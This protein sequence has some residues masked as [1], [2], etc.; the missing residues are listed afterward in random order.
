M[1]DDASCPP[2]TTRTDST[3][4]GS[5]SPD[6][7][8]R[9]LCP[10]GRVDL[11]NLSFPELERFVTVDLGQP[12]FRALQIWQWIW[13]K[14]VADFEAMT[15]VSRETRALLT[16]RAT[17]SRPEV[18]VVRQ[19]SDGTVKFLLRLADGEHV[20][21][22][23]IPSDAPPRPGDRAGR[24]T[25]CLS[26]QVGCAMGCTF[27]STGGL[28]FTRNMSMGEILGQLQAARAWLGDD[29]PERPIIRNLVYMGMGE[30]L[31]NLP[32]VMRSLQTLHHPRGLNFSARRITVS[33][34]GIEHGLRELGESGLAYLAV[35]LH[36]PTQELRARLMPKAARWPLDELVTALESY[37]LKTRER[38]T[39]EYLV[40]GGVNDGPEQARQLV[41]LCSRLKAKLNLI[42]YNPTPGS[43]YRPP[44]PESLL[45]FEKMLWDKHV[46]AIVRKSK[47]QDIEAACGQLRA[48]LRD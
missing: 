19:S 12:K 2:V 22:V 43:A 44:T 37:P 30:P 25:Q 10:D 1:I 18:A 13:R 27:C 38:I 17:L 32:Q 20:E 34:C 45:A 29:L 3:A 31:L 6:S 21:T 39:L 15:D 28:G 8:A 35:S 23:L 16:E 4:P 26:T 24:M 9:P 42:P 33:T 11:C 5:A 47:G 41:R 14:N 36:A 7:A 48:A 46:T 40:I